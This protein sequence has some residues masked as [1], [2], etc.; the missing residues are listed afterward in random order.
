ACNNDG[1]W[2]EAGATFSFQLPPPL[3]QTW[4]A[5]LIYILSIAGIGYG[6]ARLRLQALRRHNEILEAKVVERTA[7][8]ARK[9]EELGKKNQELIQS[10]RRA[11][12]IFSALSDVLPG[13]VL[14]EKYRLENKIGSGGFG[15]VYKATHLIMKR[16]VAVKIFR[17]AAGNATAESLERFL[18]E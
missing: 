13:T 10:Q 9:N 15:A 7:E 3:Y 12:K 8:L 16:P 14:D 18:L 6:G 17:P 11:Y 1:V 4:W 2:N 5:Y